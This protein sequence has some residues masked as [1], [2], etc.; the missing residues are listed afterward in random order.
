MK[1]IIT[2]FVLVAMSLSF[3]YCSDDDNDS[4]PVTEA[5]IAKKW[6]YVSYEVNGQT[7]PYENS[8]CARDYIKF[9]SGGTFEE[10]L[11]M[12]C[13][14]LVAETVN[15]TWS[16]SGNTI[17]LTFEGDAPTSATISSLTETTMQ[18]TDQWDFDD[19]GTEE[20]VKI[21]FSTQ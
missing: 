4:T 15:G 20:T 19:N 14:P 8:E 3:S 9:I 12:S 5:N 7:I 17:T 2:L 6:Y 10:Y 16:L 1:K 21:N 11:V 13:D 18:A